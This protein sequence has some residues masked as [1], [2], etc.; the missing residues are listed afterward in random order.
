MLCCLAFLPFLFVCCWFDFGLFFGG[1]GGRFCLFFFLKFF[2]KKGVQ[3]PC[4]QSC[5][6]YLHHFYSNF[7]ERGHCTCCSVDSSSM[8]IPSYCD[9]APTPWAVAGAVV[10]ALLGADDWIWVYISDTFRR[11]CTMCLSFLRLE[12]YSLTASLHVFCPG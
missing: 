7:V 11:F 2:F 6:S 5:L 9:S 12:I 3:K 4:R 10:L 1:G 8:L